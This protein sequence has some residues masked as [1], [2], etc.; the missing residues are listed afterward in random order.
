MIDFVRFEFRGQS[1]IQFEKRC[2]SLQRMNDEIKETFGIGM[3]QQTFDKHTNQINDYP[4]YMKVHNIQIKIFPRIARIEGSLHKLN[5]I[6]NNNLNHNFNDFSST[7]IC[8]NLEFLT[9][10]FPC[11]ILAKITCL[12]FGLNINPPEQSRTIISEKLYLHREKTPARS[13]SDNNMVYKEF[14]YQEYDLKI[15]DKAR[16]YRDLVCGQEIMRFEL[17]LRNRALRN[18]N[19]K[20]VNDLKIKE[21]LRGLFVTYIQKFQELRIVDS[22]HELRIP[23][24]DKKL[25]DDYVSETFWRRLRKS[26]HSQKIKR[27]RNHMENL[28]KNY[29]L[30]TTKNEIVDRLKTR[31]HQLLTT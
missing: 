14:S 20:N 7:Q 1:K 28:I 19:V 15:Y 11:I 2:E 31:F 8:E 30:D 10:L 25:L 29:L 3:L 5:N 23:E 27:L 22:Y 18:H 26:E 24:K 21:N 9:Y 6:R 17:R 4:L 13:P 16:Q 12:E